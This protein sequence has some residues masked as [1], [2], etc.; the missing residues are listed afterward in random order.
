MGYRYNQYVEEPYRMI[1]GSYDAK[2][3]KYKLY[4]GKSGMRWL[5]AIQPNAADN[6]YVEGGPNSNGFAG[7]TLDFILEDGKIISLKGPWH[8]NANSLFKDTG[9]DIRDKHLTFTVIGLDRT[10]TDRGYRT[11]IKDVIYKDEKPTIGEYY[12]GDKIAMRLAKELNRPVMCYSKS[13]GGSSCG[14]VYPD[15]IDVYGKRGTYE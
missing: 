15:Q 4:I 1:C 3:R 5:V 14:F 6:V 8:T 7:R 13:G 11:V 9:V 2:I 10:Y 12:R